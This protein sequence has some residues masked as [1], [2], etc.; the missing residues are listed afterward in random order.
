MNSV[1][2]DI[3]GI[4]EGIDQLREQRQSLKKQSEEQVCT[5]LVVTATMHP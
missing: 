3:E 2:Q 5:S 1:L 4:E